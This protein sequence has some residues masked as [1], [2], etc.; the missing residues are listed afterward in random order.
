LIPAQSTF[1]IILI[2]EEVQQRRLFGNI[3]ERC[4]PPPL[5]EL[6]LKAFLC[7]FCDP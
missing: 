3:F 1:V 7:L 5:T 4:A 2:L 6:V